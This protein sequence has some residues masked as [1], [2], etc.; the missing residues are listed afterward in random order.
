MPPR[1]I[2]NQQHHDQVLA[3]YNTFLENSRLDENGNP[4]AETIFRI[5]QRQ[6]W[7]LVKNNRILNSIE[8]NG[9]SLRHR[10]DGPPSLFDIVRR[11]LN[12]NLKDLSI[13]ALEGVPWSIMKCIWDDVLS[14]G[15]ENVQTW[16]L[17]ATVYGQ[18]PDFNTSSDEKEKEDRSKGIILKRQVS[19]NSL[20]APVSSPSFSWLVDLDIQRSSGYTRYDFLELPQLPNLG[21][22]NISRHHQ[23][24]DIDD[25]IVRTW[26]MAAVNQGKFTRLKILIARN[27]KQITSRSLE[28]LSW[29]KS[30]E[31]LDL[32]GCGTYDMEIA[33]VACWKLDPLL[34]NIIDDHDMA[35]KIIRGEEDGNKVKK[36]ILQVKVEA[37]RPTP[38]R[39][40]TRIEAVFRRQ[41]HQPNA[42]RKQVPGTELPSATAI[43]RSHPITKKPKILRNSKKKDMG[44]LLA[45]FGMYGSSSRKSD[46]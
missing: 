11:F 46:S 37:S 26:S 2:N 8:H 41:G 35:W 21:A 19:I 18:E 24:L 30:L 4:F 40:V 36:L 7:T 45:E 10:A 6:D 29:I 12:R 38:T 17:F 25:G 22:L 15:Q 5:E 16:S 42:K 34:N 9:D 31:V 39:V 28:Y 1:R 13:E 27:H 44:S 20:I 32:T 23:D 3:R 43:E 33:R 14:S